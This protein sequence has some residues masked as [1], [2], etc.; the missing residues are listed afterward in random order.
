[1]AN[2]TTIAELAKILGLSVQKLRAIHDR[3]G[4]P[5][6]QPRR[7]GARSRIIVDSVEWIDAYAGRPSEASREAG[8]LRKAQA[9]L[10]ELRLAKARGEMVT[11]KEWVE[12]VGSVL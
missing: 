10:M 11:V 7:K 9:D 3:L 1:M 8:R 6:E 2:P 4:R 5:G 12:S